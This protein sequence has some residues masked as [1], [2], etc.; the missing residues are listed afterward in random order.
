MIV[1]I[2]NFTTHSKRE[3]HLHW[4]RECLSRCCQTCIALNPDKLFVGAVQGVLLGHIVF[5][6]GI[7]PNPEMVEVIQSLKPP[8]DVKG[9]QKVS[10]HGL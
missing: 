4:I 9:I 8:T 7:E 3:D 5:G 2:D 10:E 6:A 1:F